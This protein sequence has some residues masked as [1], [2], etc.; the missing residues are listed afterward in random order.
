MMDPGDNPFKTDPITYS[1]LPLG[2]PSNAQGGRVEEL[3][4]MGYPLPRAPQWPGRVPGDGRLVLPHVATFTSISNL[5]SRSYLSTFDEALLDNQR[6]ALVMRRDPVIEEALWSRKVPT[7]QLDWHIEPD[8]HNDRRQRRMAEEV[9]KICKAIPRLQDLRMQL[10]DDMWYGRYG[11]QFVLTNDW[12]KGWRRLL[13]RDHKPINGDK[14]VF[15]FS[16]QVAILVHGAYRGPVI[17]TDRG[18]AHPLSPSEREQLVLGM[19]VPEDADY[20]E[21]EMAGKIYGVGLRSKIYWWWWQRN[22]VTQW[23]FDFLQTIGVGGLTIFYYEEGNKASENAATQAANNCQSNQAILIPRRKGVNGAVEE[24]NKVDR[25]EPSEAGAQLLYDIIDKYYNGTMRS[26][27][28]GELLTTQTA[29]TGLGSGVAEQHARTATRITRFD[30]VRQQGYLTTDLV[31]VI[32]RKMY[33]QMPP[34]RCPLTW[35]YDVEQPDPEKFMT[36]A[37]TFVSIGGTVD[38]NQARGVLGFKKPEAGS[39]ELFDPNVRMQMEQ[40]AQQQEA[41][42]SG[43]GGQP[44]MPGAAPGGAGGG[45]GGAEMGGAG[46]TAG[47]GPAL[48]GQTAGAAP[49]P[50]PGSEAEGFAAN[51]YQEGPVAGSPAVAEDSYGAP[52]TGNLLPQ[53][54]NFGQQPPYGNPEEEAPNRAVMSKNGSRVR[55]QKRSE[56][57]Y[58]VNFARRKK[59]AASQPAGSGGGTCQPGQTQSQTHCTPAQQPQAGQQPAQPADPASQWKSLLGGINSGETNSA[60]YQTKAKEVLA[61]IDKTQL[62]PFLESIGIAQRPT[63]RAHALRLM[64]EVLG[65]QVAMGERAAAMKGHYQKLRRRLGVKNARRV[66]RAALKLMKKGGGTGCRPFRPGH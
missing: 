20:L 19:Y 54:G 33:P 34:E 18:R 17:Y 62:R 3:G 47:G 16:G 9:E 35:Q 25:I 7:A 15:R 13:V 21:G 11:I 42:E 50:P 38:E 39:E 4:E 49:P 29:S 2:P 64:T 45:G 52:V 51:E 32:Q 66:C 26:Y 48:V 43:M 10:L 5:V 59:Y 58:M 61:S 28:K 31:H 55:M 24:I 27:I 23:M 60:N 37:K 8:D 6:N 30:A 22:V 41:Q 65:N 40:V 56:D 53:G 36:A 63:S 46:P 12:S 44:G 1:P 57:A 14:L